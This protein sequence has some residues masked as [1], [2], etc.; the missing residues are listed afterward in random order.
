MKQTLFHLPLEE[1]G[2]IKKINTDNVTKERLH[3]LGLISNV[4]ITPVRI[5]PLGCPRVYQ[6]LNTLI[7][8]RNSVA[9]RVE[10]KVRE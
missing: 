10:I 6:C 5:T 7:A 8:L 2:T 1:E 3:S 4:E 9:K